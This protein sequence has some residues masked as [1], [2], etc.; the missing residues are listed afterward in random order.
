V[1]LFRKNGEEK[2][3]C[4]SGALNLV[5]FVRLLLFFPPNFAPK[6]TQLL[7]YEIPKLQ[8]KKIFFWTPV[9]AF[10]QEL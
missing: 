2:R 10:D 5:V 1:T 6:P 9:G 7:F 4:V 3:S 8:K